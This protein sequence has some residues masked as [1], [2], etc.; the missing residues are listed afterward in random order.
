MEFISFKL[1]IFTVYNKIPKYDIQ[2]ISSTV[3]FLISM[4]N[5]NLQGSSIHII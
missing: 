2:Y 4:D 5:K 3:W 1:L